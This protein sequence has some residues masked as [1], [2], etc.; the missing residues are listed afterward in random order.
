MEV[1]EMGMKENLSIIRRLS[2]RKINIIQQEKNKALNEL[3][4]KLTKDLYKDKD[5]VVAR[6]KLIAIE[7]NLYDI[8]LKK[9]TKNYVDDSDIKHHTNTEIS[10]YFGYNYSNNLIDNNKEYKAMSQMFY[11]K[12]EK[13]KEL[14]DNSEVEILSKTA[15][16]NTTLQKFV[17]AL[18]KM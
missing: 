5:I 3:R 1:F 13:I 11:D 15:E 10:S 9:Y 7:K 6:E 17:E 18:N 4:E 2:E 14:V 16:S 8:M 12:T